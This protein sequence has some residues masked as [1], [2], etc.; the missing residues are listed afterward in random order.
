MSIPNRPCSFSK[1][2]CETLALGM[3]ALDLTTDDEKALISSI[4]WNAMDA[5]S[6]EDQRLPHNSHRHPQP[7]WADHVLDEP[8]RQRQVHLIFQTVA[9]LDDP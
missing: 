2:D 8:G 4:F 1:R 5:L 7:S 9:A 6:E 3:S